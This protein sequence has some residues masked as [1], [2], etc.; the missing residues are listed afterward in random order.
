MLEKEQL[1]NGKSHNP[2]FVGFV[3]LLAGSLGKIDPPL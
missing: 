3:D 2:Y 1:N